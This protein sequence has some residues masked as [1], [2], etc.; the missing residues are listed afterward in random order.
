MVVETA[1]APAQ[2]LTGESYS[3]NAHGAHR[4]RK[5]AI[6]GAGIMGSRIALHFAN[7]G[8]E[9]LLLDIAPGELTPQEAAQGLTLESPAVRNR[10]VSQLYQ[11]ALKGKPSPIYAAAFASRISLGNFT[12]D[13]HKVADCDWIIEVVVE[14]L[15]IKKSLYERIEQY[16]KPGT[17]ITSNTSGIPMARL[18]E[19]RSPDFQ[20]NF[21]GTH[22]FNPPRYLQLL[23]IIPAPTTAPALIDFLLKYGDLYLGKKTVLCK[24]TPAFI[25]NR[26]GIYAIMD[27]FHLIEKYE[28]T[29]EEVDAL[30]GPLVGNPKS[31]TCRT[32]DVVGL[33]TAV[34]VA[35]GIY[36]NCPTDERRDIYRLPAYVQYMVDNNMWGDKSNQG[37]YKKSKTASGESVILSLNLKTKEYVPQ[38]KPAS[39]TLKAAKG[40]DDLAK[41]IKIIAAGKDKHA[42]F[43]REASYGLFAYVSHRVPEIADELYQVDAALSAGFGWEL[44]PFTK[45]DILGV[46]ETVE[47][48]E[49]AGFK[50]AAW[51]KEMLA[52]GHTSFYKV[53]NGVKKYYDQVSKSY[54]AIPGAERFIILDNL[55]STNVVWKNS[56]ASIFDLGDGI[57]N[58]EFHTKMNALGAEIVEAIHKGIDLAEKDFRGLVIGNQGENFSAGANLMMIYMWAM[59]KKFDELDFAVRQFQNTNMRLRYSAIPVVVAPHGLTLGGGCEMSMHADAVQAA[60][61][62]Y[63]GLVEVGVGLLPGGGG[64]KEFAVRLSDAY[65]KGDVEINDFTTVFMT[66]AQAKVATSAHEAFGLGILQKNKDHITINKDRLLADAKRAAIQLAEAG[67]TRPVERK[68]V[69]V[70][71]KSGLG[72]VYAATYQMQ[73][74][75]YATEHDRLI[76]E[77]IGFVLCGGDLSSPTLVTEQYLLDLEREGFLSLCGE[78]KTLDRIQTML[79]T[80]KPLRN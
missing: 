27:L 50:I 54:K 37:F 47:A 62:T 11:T 78:Q 69:R 45:W 21:C 25:A 22:F 29:V 56:G 71:G 35:A 17:I 66:V 41:R 59:E 51:V 43:M 1:Q 68:D 24:D 9:A 38:I 30:T 64:T 63:I 49:A 70:T 61:E 76:A 10:I 15:D 36:D 65:V 53:E 33:D 44:G 12:D 46:K 42:D 34:K 77:K 19:D 39:D 14:R 26:V 18:V 23:E 4:I 32:C 52:A 5:V 28:L 60:A 75:G 79:Q 55:R 48:M 74:A 3:P 40:Q 72:A 67:Y 13:L 8:V 16:R 73:Y 57:L 31:A 2:T 6:L 20:R 80:G 7:I 58:V